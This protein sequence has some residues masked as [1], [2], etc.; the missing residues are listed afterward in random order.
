MMT[1]VIDELL[2]ATFDYL[3]RGNRDIIHEIHSCGIN[4]VTRARMRVCLD[5]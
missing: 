4:N 3:D 2:F 5:A 1:T